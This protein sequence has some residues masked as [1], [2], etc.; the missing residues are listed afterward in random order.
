MNKIRILTIAALC[1]LLAGHVEAQTYTG[2][3][4]VSAN[5]FQVSA[6][7]P[8]GA[9]CI[10]NGERRV[11]GEVVNLTNQVLTARPLKVATRTRC[12]ASSIKH[13]DTVVMF[14]TRT[15]RTEV[16]QSPPMVFTTG[17]FYGC[18]TYQA[19]FVCNANLK[20]LMIDAIPVPLP[21]TPP[22]V[23]TPPTTQT[24]VQ[25]ATEHQSFSHVGRARFGLA[26]VGWVEKDVAGYFMCNAAAE[27]FGSDP[28]PERGKVCEVRQ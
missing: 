27:W 22:V 26:S 14:T 12:L 9:Y 21:V 28:A 17:A 13:G 3:R 7:Q 5:T 19:N 23:V 6:V 2:P 1:G 8:E 4:I 10:V 18:R 11:E 24:W 16:G 15:D 20:M 25:V